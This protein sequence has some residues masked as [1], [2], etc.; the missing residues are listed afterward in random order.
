MIGLLPELD[1]PQCVDLACGT[2]DTCGL[3]ARRYPCGVIV[4]V[5]IS[6]SMLAIAQHRHPAPSLRFLRQDMGNLEFQDA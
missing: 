2:G 1:S 5:N 4:G 3:L 6:D